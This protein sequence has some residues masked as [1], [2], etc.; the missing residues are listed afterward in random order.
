MQ[1]RQRN[2]IKQRSPNQKPRTESGVLLGSIE[3]VGPDVASYSM[4]D[5]KESYNNESPILLTQNSSNG[6]DIDTFI[7]ND[8][9]ETITELAKEKLIGP[10]LCAQ[11]VVH[12]LIKSLFLKTKLDSIVLS[13]KK[14][15]KQ[16]MLIGLEYGIF[17]LASKLIDK[18]IL[19][20]NPVVNMESMA[21][22]ELE[23]EIIRKLKGENI[24]LHD[25]N[26]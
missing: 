26:N 19:Y 10:I 14:I 9:Q 12:N 18:E 16:N 15:D 22:K 3:N 20:K 7:D 17:V 25:Y 1:K 13:N 6:L 23:T 8:L 4:P 21:A 2:P 24:E 5:F 11:V